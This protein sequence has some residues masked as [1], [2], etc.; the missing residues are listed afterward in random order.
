M[1]NLSLRKWYLDAI[2]EDG[3]AWIAY[4]ATL[5]LGPLSLALSSVL[6]SAPAQAPRT[7]TSIRGGEEP[8]ERDGTIAWSLDA[9]DLR[10]TWSRED[11]PAELELLNNANG[12][13]RWRCAAPRARVE[14]L[15]AGERVHAMGY[16]EVMDMTIAPWRLPIRELRW[17]RAVGAG[18]SVVWIDWRGAHER[19]DVL[20]DGSP[21]AARVRDDAIEGDTF[22]LRL[23]RDR[24]LRDG[25]IGTT[26]LA[27]VPGISSW[28]PAQFLTTHETKW[29]SRA[30]FASGPRSWSGW[31][32]HEV[33]RFPEPEP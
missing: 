23:T 32:I 21:V 26:A 2:A 29:I 8:R 24:T 31:A 18:G 3:R 25:A 22:S 14:L 13:I 33:V 20:V 10:G 17:G 28:A 1:A 16:A 11:P 5:R 7:R 12:S 6:E 15:T 4:W 19:T 30:A 27:G 9:L